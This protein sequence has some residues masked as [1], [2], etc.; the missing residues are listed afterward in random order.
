MR[1]KII[2]GILVI[3]LIITIVYDGPKK[4]TPTAKPITNS[5]VITKTD[6]R[7]GEYLATPKGLPL[8]VDN[9]DTDKTS[10]CLVSCLSTWPAYGNTSNA[11]NLPVNFSAFKRSDTGSLQFAY[12]NH[13]LY[14]FVDDSASKMAGPGVSPLFKL[15]TP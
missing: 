3:L 6:S 15:A 13:P 9:Q 5:V 10:N 8:Y 4:S 11:A 14:T 1:P 2:L 7:L 12:K